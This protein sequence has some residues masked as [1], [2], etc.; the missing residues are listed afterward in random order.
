[1]QIFVRD[2]KVRTQRVTSLLR[3]KIHER[4]TP[5]GSLYGCYADIEM[6]FNTEV[7][8]AEFASLCRVSFVPLFGTR[9]P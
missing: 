4:F 9:S 7:G 8:P 1:M 5:R 6:G 2:Q 3:S